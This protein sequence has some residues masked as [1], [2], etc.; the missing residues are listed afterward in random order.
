MRP[1]AKE[2]QEDNEVLI[3]ECRLVMQH[4]KSELLH[5]IANRPIPDISDEAICSFARFTDGIPLK[6]YEK[7]IHSVPE[8]VNLVSL[9]DAVPNAGNMDLPLDLTA[10]S[11]RCKNASLLF[12]PKSFTAIQ[13]AFYPP[14]S[15]VLLFH[16]G[17][18]VGTGSNNPAASKLSMLRAVKQ[19]QV[20]AGVSIAIRRYTVINQVGAASL[21]ARLDLERFGS[22]HRDSA[23]FD[24]KLF[25]GLPWRAQEL[26]R[27]SICVLS[28]E[29]PCFIIPHWQ[30]GRHRVKQPS[31]QQ[32]KYATSSETNSG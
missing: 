32:T 16:T 8:L 2:K 4:I 12:A 11:K 30:A 1:K 26:H 6:N 28:T 25:V 10:I 14:R 29:K 13:F 18:L 27:H 23:H 22:Q 31:R 9:A 20:E 24:R 3:K 21:G 19:I 7:C 15:R 17:R 5:A